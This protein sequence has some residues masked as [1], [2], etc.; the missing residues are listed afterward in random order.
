MM[1]ATIALALV[2]MVFFQ[3]MLLTAEDASL[4]ERLRDISGEVERY[5]ASVPEAE[6]VFEQ[7]SEDVELARFRARMRRLPSNAEVAVVLRNGD[8]VE[9]ELADTSSSE[10]FAL[11]IRPGSSTS[12]VKKRFRYEEVEARSSVLPERDGWIPIER[13]SRI[14]TGKKVELLLVDET[15]TKGRYASVTREAVIL[16]QGEGK[17]R[18]LPL[19]DVAS[20]RTRGMTSSTKIAIIAGSIAGGLILLPFATGHYSN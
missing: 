14:E 18:E 15:T 12:S 1:R 13:I 16:D 6:L 9:G 11:W 2:S 5:V 8:R 7:R 3:P 20:V 17:A 10:E 19:D 4:R